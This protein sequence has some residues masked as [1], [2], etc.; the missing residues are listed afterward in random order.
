MSWKGRL[1]LNYRLQG[2]RTVAQDRHSGPLRV[3]KAL[4]PPLTR[5]C[6]HVL[7][8]PPGGLAGGD[9]L[10]I[11]LHQDSGTQVLITTPGATRFYRSLGPLALQ[12][13]SIRLEGDAR[14]QWLPL[15]SL[16]YGGCHA[17]NRL[18]FELGPAAQMMGWDMLSLGL[19]AAEDSF[20]R[21]QFVQHLEC[22]GLWLERGRLDAHDVLLR[23]SPLGLAGHRVM[24]T[25]WLA[26][27]HD[28]D[29]KMLEEALASA[30]EVIAQA[31][32]VPAAA[33]A[34]NPQVLVVRALSHRVE[35]LF[36]LFKAIRDQWHRVVW[37]EEAV[38]PRLWAT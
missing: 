27:G 7:V 11:A 9:E 26:R 1:E 18:R 33:T 13:V 23:E 38:Q 16:A 25:L 36:Q 32:D 14:L 28:W 19:P 22:P 20:E 12:D 21:G 31:V 5:E 29:A 2:E 6:H 24:G 30:R 35:P 37:A 10:E 8:H 34:P 17:E 15:E 3:L 4:Y